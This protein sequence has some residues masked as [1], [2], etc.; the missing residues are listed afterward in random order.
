MP[1]ITVIIPTYGRGRRVFTTIE[2]IQRC[3]PIPRTIIIHIDQSDGELEREIAARSPDVL[4]LSSP[5]RVGPGGGRHQCL[6][7]CQ[8]EFAASFDDDSYPVDPDYFARAEELFRQNADAAVI[9]AAIWQ[10]GEEQKPRQQTV[11]R[12][13]DFTGCGHVVRLAA[14]RQV[15]GYL[16]RPIAYGM[17]ETDLALQFFARGWKIYD[18]GQLRVFHDTAL[19][20]HEGSSMAAGSLANVALFGFLHYP[21]SLWPHALLQVG[22]KTVDSWKRGRSAGILPGLFSTPKICWNFRNY[23]APLSPQVVREF[24]RERRSKALT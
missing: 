9:G 19:S 3:D 15:R 6:L 10:Q 22:N 5:T 18:S 17:E 1:A 20:H 14:Y 4:L 16:P 7:H 2:K 21:A 13:A 8:T 24:L 12:Q 23:R 11:S